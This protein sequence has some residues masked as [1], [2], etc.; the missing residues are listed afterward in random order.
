MG[1]R[2]REAILLVKSEY[3]VYLPVICMVAPRTI[4]THRCLV[5]VGMTG[6]TIG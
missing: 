3:I 6:N 5:Q 2:E 4:I 1:T